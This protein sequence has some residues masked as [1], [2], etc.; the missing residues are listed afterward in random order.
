MKTRTLLLLA[1]TCGLAILVA[2]T[3]QLLRVANQSSSSPLLALGASGKA[4][5]ATVTLVSVQADASTITAT[6][7]AG[8]V[9]DGNGIG[10]FTMVSAGSRR[11]VSGGTCTALT[12][13]VQRCT[14]VFDNTGLKGSAR[15]L[16]FDRA[17]QQRRWLLVKQ[18]G[19]TV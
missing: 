18:D 8:G 11:K 2:G 19:T 12:T 15:Q 3:V 14:L 9:D 5:D 7:S 1:V 10:G 6:I 4:G 13:A 17:G 16:L